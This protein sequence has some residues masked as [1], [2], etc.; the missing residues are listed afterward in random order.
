MLTSAKD[1][2][3]SLEALARWGEWDRTD[4]DAEQR[5]KARHAFEHSLFVKKASN[6]TCEDAG[7]IEGTPC[8]CNV[9]NK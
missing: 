6:R 5:Q 3:Y 8:I 2:F 4:L 7:V 1:V 9:K